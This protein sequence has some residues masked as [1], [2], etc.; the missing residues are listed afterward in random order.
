[1]SIELKNLIV[2]EIANNHMGDVKHGI[3]LINTFSKICKKYKHLNFAF[4]LQY[5]DL[6]TFIHKSVKND[7]NNHYVKRFS[8]TKLVEKDFNQLIGAIKSNG[9]LSM[10]TPFDNKSLSL[11]MKQDIDILKVASCSFTDWPLLEDMVQLNKPIIASTAGASEVDIDSVISF[12]KN[13]GK[14]YA[15][16]HCVAQYPTPNEKLNLSQIDYLTNRYPDTTIG[17]STH[18]D[19][20]NFNFILMAAAKGAK[21]FEK[22]IGLPTDLYP[23]N[24]YS[25]TPAQFENWLEALSLALTVC[26]Q[27]LRRTPVDKAEQESLISLRRGIFANRKIKKGET[28]SRKDIYFAF[29]PTKNQFTANNYSKYTSF[30]SKTNIELD[31]GISHDNTNILEQRSILEGITKK[32]NKLI[33]DANIHLPSPIEME[34]SHHYGLDEFYKYGMVI[35]TLIN[36]SYCKKLLVSLPGQIH[37]AQFHKKKEESFRLIYGDLTLTI[38]NEDLI[39]KLGE[40]I[41]IEKGAIHKFSSKSGSIVEEI[42]DTHTTEDSY[43]ID[44]KITQNQNRKTIINFYKNL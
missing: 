9:Y 36:R 28:I 12:F 23:V 18:E 30:V 42:S 32:I 27:G 16:M 43:Y 41:T 6:E 1:M 35:F 17:Y 11:I 4:K 19:P 29:P 14:D 26:G 15:I 31:D 8:E 3:D 13:R 24:K 38:D 37:P 33:T 22:H 21:I 5:R 20:S 10:V 40:I 25:V 2:L 34:I 7:F 44:D 39:M